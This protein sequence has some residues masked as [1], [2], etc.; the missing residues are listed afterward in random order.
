MVVFVSALIWVPIGVLIGFSPRASQIVQP[1]AQFFAAFPVNLLFPVAAFI[2]LKYH[3]NINVWCSPLMI[4]G[5]QW[6]ILFNV[7]VGTAA[8]PIGMRQAVSSLNV[9]G[10]LW[11]RK[12]AL[13]AI[14]PY[15]VTGAITA[16]GGAWNI[17]IVA[18][19]IEWGQH[20]LVATG[21]GSYVTQVSHSGNFP[22]LTLGISVM[23]LFV[24]VINRLVWKPLYDLAQQRYQ[25]R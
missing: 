11:W 5:T 25:I 9:R 7:I 1:I 16:A 13:P 17:S 23:S 18:E 22:A 4:L 10:W 6:Y 24:I 15:L 3:L 19:V 2:I 12:L 8:L 21:L 20:H 14:F